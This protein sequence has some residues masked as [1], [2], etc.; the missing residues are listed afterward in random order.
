MRAYLKQKAAHASKEKGELH[1]YEAKR[2]GALYEKQQENRILNGK[3]KK[4]GQ[5]KDHSVPSVKP[6]L[7]NGG[8]RVDR[9]LVLLIEYPDF[10][11]NSIQPN[12]TDMYYKDYTREHYEDMIFGGMMAITKDRTEKNSF[13]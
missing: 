3:G 8:K 11:H 6:E 2:A 9:V 13:P 1:E 4:L 10:P 7:W 5:A 12:E